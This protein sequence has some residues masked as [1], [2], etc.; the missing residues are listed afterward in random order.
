M[1]LSSQKSLSLN[2]L[3]S[4]IELQ[5]TLN[6]GGINFVIKGKIDRIDEYDNHIRII[7]Y[8]SGSVKVSDLSFRKWEEFSEAPY[9]PK[10][11]QLLIYA[12]LYIK[13]NPSILN[14]K[15]IVGNFAFKNLQEGLI[16]LA[17]YKDE[18]FTIKAKTISEGIT[19]KSVSDL[20]MKSSLIAGSS[21]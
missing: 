6:I 8:K 21:K 17:R 9:K 18:P 5:H 19:Y 7:D 2:I 16:T 20:L 10:A 4:E 1:L 11:L 3:E 12:Y 14:R 15:V 13:N